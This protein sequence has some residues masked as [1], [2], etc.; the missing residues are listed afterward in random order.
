MTPLCDPICDAIDNAVALDEGSR[1]TPFDIAVRS[2]ET[3]NESDRASNEAIPIRGR[4]N[5]P[6]I[7]QPDRRREQPADPPSRGREGAAGAVRARLP[8]TLVLLAPPTVGARRRRLPG[9]RGRPTRLR[10]LVKA[11]AH[12][13]LPDH[14][15]GGRPGGRRRGTRRDLRYHRRP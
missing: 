3:V 15:T 7:H 13:R 9:G 12:P 6:E 8:R 4:T 1:D 5:G 2:A 14:R 10:P 11:P